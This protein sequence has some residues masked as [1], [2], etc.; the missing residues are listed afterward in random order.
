MSHLLTWE[1]SVKNQTMLVT[2]DYDNEQDTFTVKAVNIYQNGKFVVEISKL[3]EGDPLGTL[4]NSINWLQVYHDLK[5][6]QERVFGKMPNLN[7]ASDNLFE[8]I[9]WY[10]QPYID[11]I[12]KRNA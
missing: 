6:T 1:H 11:A 7:P 12:R 5:D 8:A 9:L 2:V 3:L 4:V 10:Q